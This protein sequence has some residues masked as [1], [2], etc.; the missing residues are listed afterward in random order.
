MKSEKGETIMAEQNTFDITKYPE[1]PK[2]V[3]KYMD[4]LETEEEKMA[5]LNLF[6][7]LSFQL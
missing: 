4:W 7:F 1:G 3:I 5:A 6:V 2:E